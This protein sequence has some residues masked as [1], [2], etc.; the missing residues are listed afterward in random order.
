VGVGIL[1]NEDLK[2]HVDELISIISDNAEIKVT[3]EEITSELEK[4]LEYGVPIDQA[5]QTILKK[6]S[7]GNVSIPS[8]LKRMLIADL[9]PDQKSVKILAQVVS[10]NPKEIIV[11]GETRQI[12]YGILQDESGTVSFT[13]WKEIDVEKGDVIEISNAYTGE[14]RGAVQLNIGDRITVEKKESD[15]LP[16]DAFKPKKKQIKDLHSGIGSVDVK[17]VIIEFE[18]REV[19]VNDE[20]KKV[21]SGVLGDETGKI[22]IT[23]WSDFKLKKGDTVQITG[24]Y[25]KNWKGI[26]QLTFDDKATVK[27]QK[28]AILIDDVPVRAIEMYKLVEQPGV[29]DISVEGTVTIIQSGSGFILRCPDCN[30]VLFNG[31]CRVHGNVEGVADLRIKCIVDDGTGSVSAIFD[32]AL[33]EKLI[34]KNLE[35]CKEMSPDV[36]VDTILSSVYAH[37]VNLRG[38]ALIDNFGTTFIVKNADFIEKD[39]LSEASNLASELEEL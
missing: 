33:T 22:P 4:F 5:K 23:C 38:N 17:G 32:R 35:E 36:L 8:N 20:K 27:K 1:P 34:G 15:A 11:K 31:E 14:W 2:T 28:K 6:F 25:V 10:I 18:S 26:P 39:V 13:S 37:R 21:Y 16:K 7:S 9:I 24:G 12:Y 19:E 3:E 30:R 29:Y